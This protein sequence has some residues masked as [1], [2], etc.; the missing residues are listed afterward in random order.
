MGKF[1]PEGPGGP[2]GPRGPGIGLPFVIQFTH[3]SPFSPA[4]QTAHELLLI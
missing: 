1:L 3:V 2:G 4:K